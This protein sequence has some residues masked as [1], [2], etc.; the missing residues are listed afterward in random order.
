MR[1]LF[2]PWK[3][4]KYRTVNGTFVSIASVRRGPA[5]LRSPLRRASEVP[6]EAQQTEKNEA[7]K[8]ATM[9][10]SDRRADRLRLVF[11]V[12]TRLCFTKQP[13]LP[14]AAMNVDRGQFVGRG[15][16]TSCGYGFLA[17]FSCKARV[18]CPS[19]TSRRMAQTAAH[20]R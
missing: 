1:P 17:A 9:Q 15:K 2:K 4:R 12:G 18:V 20:P 7:D 8:P 6:H 19:C 16:C 13:H 11:G 5:A 10:N 3:L 14:S